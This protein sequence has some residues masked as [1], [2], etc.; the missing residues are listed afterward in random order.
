MMKPI[1]ARER[2]IPVISTGTGDFVGGTDVVAGIAE[3]AAA[4]VVTGTGAMSWNVSFV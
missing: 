2:A 1:V 4:A 3:V